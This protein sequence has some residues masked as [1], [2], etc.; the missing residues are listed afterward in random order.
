MLITP[1]PIDENISTSIILLRWIANNYLKITSGQMQFV[2]KRVSNF[3][4]THSCIT[5]S[6]AWKSGSTSLWYVPEYQF[7][8]TRAKADAKIKREERKIKIK[9]LKK[10]SVKAPKPKEKQLI[11]LPSNEITGGEKERFNDVLQHFNRFQRRITLKKMVLLFS[12]LVHIKTPDKDINHPTILAMVKRIYHLNLKNQPSI[13]ADLMKYSAILGIRDQ[14]LWRKLISEMYMSDFS[15]HLTFYAEIIRNI[16]KVNITDPQVWDHLQTETI[17]FVKYQRPRMNKKV[18]RDLLLGFIWNKIK[19]LPELEQLIISSMRLQAHLYNLEFY[20]ELLRV[21]SSY[22]FK[23]EELW[24]LLTKWTNIR[25]KDY[26]ASNATDSSNDIVSS[27]IFHLCYNLA[28]TEQIQN[29]KIY[30]SFYETVSAWYENSRHC[31]NFETKLEVLLGLVAM[32][33][34]NPIALNKWAKESTDLLSVESNE[35][36]GKAVK[37]LAMIL[38]SSDLLLK[39]EKEQADILINSLSNRR[40]LLGPIDYVRLVGKLAEFPTVIGDKM[41]AFT[42]MMA[43]YIT[44]YPNHK[45]SLQSLVTKLNSHGIVSVE[46]APHL[47]RATS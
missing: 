46:N 14:H 1:L 25:L 6:S 26:L 47:F 32:S 3:L 37:N 21:L 43:Y 30:E 45:A 15:N 27:I 8:K 33:W 12:R 40:I 19:L 23:D 11:P 35:L 28:K 22:C 2:C 24:T 18:P 9:S 29:G 20:E 7:G 44:V 17:K 38:S 13:L 41:R 42:G 36:S 31:H 39:L 16:P 4:G 10:K 34:N 5:L